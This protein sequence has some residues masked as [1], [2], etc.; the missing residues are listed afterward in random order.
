MY[1]SSNS[2]ITYKPCETDHNKKSFT[3][4]I[5]LKQIGFQWFVLNKFST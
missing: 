3:S 2:K 5:K 1:K 4:L